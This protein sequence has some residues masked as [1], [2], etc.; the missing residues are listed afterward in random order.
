MKKITNFLIM[1]FVCLSGTTYAQQDVNDF[2]DDM[3]YIADGFAAPA[4]NSAAYQGTAGW[5]TSAKSLDLWKVDVSFHGNALFV[6]PSKKEFTVS[7]SNLKL[8]QINDGANA[9]VVPTAFGS[10]SNVKFSG[11]VMG[12]DFSFDAIEGIDKGAL[13]Y[14]FAQV[15]V[16]LPFETEVG[17]RA[18]PELE[19][20]GSKF[21]TYGIAIKHNF[22]QYF[23]FNRKEDLQ[24]AAV[25]SYNIF[26]VK[27]GFNPVAVPDV[28][29]LNLIN[30][31]A[32]MI[33]GELLA[34]KRYESFEIFG[35]LGVA[36]S[37]FDY[38][39]DG[40]GFGLPLINQELTALSDNEA[41]FKGDIGFNLY[42]TRFKI[43]TMATAG[44][45]FNVNLGLH[46]IL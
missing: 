18:L 13:F 28:V 21:S 25:I 23:R 10:T 43:S 19:V 33:M 11:N 22:S 31:D 6:P 30:V 1:A 42:F 2:V 41:Q 14:P 4:S 29:T 46:F 8:L 36:K 44:K 24:L 12:Q 38:R 9:A 20:D 15:S 40:S 45:F 26:N 3:L 17:V 16:G 27:Y 5:F 7:A 37:N 39:F 34:S 35:A 32:D